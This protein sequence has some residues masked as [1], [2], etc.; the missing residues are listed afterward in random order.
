MLYVTGDLVSAL[1]YAGY[2]YKSQTISELSA[3]D[4]PTRSVM[5]PLVMTYDVL[6]VAFG[7][8][9]WRFAGR[10]R[11]LRVVAAVLIAQGAFDFSMAPFSPMHQ[12]EVLAAGGGTASDTRHLIVGGAD[13]LSMLVVMGFGAKALGKRFGIYSLAT[14]LVLLVFGTL[15]GMDGPRIQDNEPT[16]W[17]GVTERTSVFSFM[18]WVSV[19]AVTLL[20][21]PIQPAGNDRGEGAAPHPS[22]R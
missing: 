13:L 5:L 2:S 9:V 4:A 20:R 15:M 17:V 11:G 22:G 10:S 7:L 8:G 14:V 21:R 18:L 3:I 16:P 19:L 12:R 6:I 1:R